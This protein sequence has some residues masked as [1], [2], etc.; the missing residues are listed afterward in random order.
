MLKRF[1][2]SNSIKHVMKNPEATLEDYIAVFEK[3]EKNNLTKL[4]KLRRDNYTTAKRVSGALKSCIDAHGPIT[5]L[6]IGSATKRV[7]GALLENPNE[8]K[9]FLTKL[10]NLWKK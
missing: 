6:L 8:Q 5:K 7:V 1:K 3:Y 9:S 4:K 10:K 2:L